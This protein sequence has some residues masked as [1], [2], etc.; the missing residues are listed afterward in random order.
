MTDPVLPDATLHALHDHK[1]VAT[2][3]TEPHTAVTVTPAPAPTVTPAAPA[4]IPTPAEV[5]AKAAALAATPA[6]V[7]AKAAALAATAAAKEAVVKASNAN[8][9]SAQAALVVAG[10]PGHWVA[11]KVTTKAIVKPAVA[12]VKPLPV[13]VSANSAQLR[14]VAAAALAAAKTVKAKPV[15]KIAP[16]ATVVTPA[17]AKK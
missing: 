5:A 13:H 4:S 1:A 8:V 10:N 12:F 2:P 11:P 3:S 6:E 7:A 17:P 15:A 9:R 14:K 16:K